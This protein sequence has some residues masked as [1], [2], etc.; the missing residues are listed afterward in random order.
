[1]YTTLR[2]QPEF[3]QYFV[4]ELSEFLGRPMQNDYITA[5]DFNGVVEID[6]VE[7]SKLILKDAFYVSKKEMNKFNEE[8]EVFGVFTEHLGYFEFYREIIKSIKYNSY[9]TIV[10]NGIT[11]RQE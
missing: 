2:Y 9:T 1:M 6:M 8:E 5:E 7:G 3:V 11:Y 10:K 4:N